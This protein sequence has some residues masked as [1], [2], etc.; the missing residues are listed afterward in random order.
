MDHLSTLFHAS[1]FE[2][3]AAAETVFGKL[4]CERNKK[5]LGTPSNVSE[6]TITGSVPTTTRIVVKQHVNLS[7]DPEL[8]LTIKMSSAKHTWRRPWN[9][10]VPYYCMSS[11]YSLRPF[12]LHSGLSPYEQWSIFTTDSILMKMK[13]PLNICYEDSKVTQVLKIFMLGAG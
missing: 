6:L 2:R 7:R 8:E 12:M 5:K 10:L 1:P 11:S 9:K 3:D 13:N 4:E